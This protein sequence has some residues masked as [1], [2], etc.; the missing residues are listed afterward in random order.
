MAMFNRENTLMSGQSLIPYKS[1]LAENGRSASCG[2]RWRNRKRSE[3]INIAGRLHVSPEETSIVYPTRRS[4]NNGHEKNNLVD[5][6]EPSENGMREFPTY[7]LVTAA[8]SFPAIAQAITNTSGDPVVAL[9]IETCGGNALNPFRGDIR[10]LSLGTGQGTRWLID[11]KATGYDL[12]PLKP[13]LESALLVGHN[14]KFDLR[15]LRHKCGLKATRVFC[16][17]T[18]SRLLA[19][20]RKESKDDLTT[21]VDR[22]LGLTLPQDCS[23]SDWG[24]AQLTKEQ[25]DYAV[26][27][28][29][30]LADLKTVLDRKLTEAKLG[31][32]ASLE[33][34]LILVVVEMEHAG[35]PVDTGKLHR[36]EA[37]CSRQTAAAL[38]QLAK[39]FS[40]PKLNPNSALQLKAGFRKIGLE[41]DGTS[42][43]ALADV[44]HPTVKTLLEHRQASEQLKWVK[45]LIK[46]TGEDGRIH[47]SFNPTGADTGRFT[48]SNP[49]MQNIIRGEVRSC[50]VP[51]PGC[52]LV[53]ADYSQ[54][55]LRAV[56]A[57]ASETRMQEAYRNGEDLHRKTASIILEKAPEQ[58]TKEDRQLAKPVNFGL[59]YGLGAEGLVEYAKKDFGVVLS[60][61]QAET[62]RNRFF[63]EYEGLAQWRQEARQS[64]QGDA[65]ETRT[66]LGR[67]RL[68]PEQTEVWER[69]TR[70][71]NT[72]V[73]GSC[74]DGLK[75]AMVELFKK[76]P[77]GARII[78]TVHDELIVETPEAEAEAVKQL[79]AD[80]MT[81]T[82]EVIFPEVPIEVE[83][84][85]CA[86]WGEK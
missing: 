81:E 20:G 79:V 21:V 73:Q 26:S 10:L 42:A 67:R 52:K 7:D 69:F 22:H 71:V 86:T 57:I 63:T 36:L 76:L 30:H 84:N 1:F 46:F 77:A 83:A 60:L 32:V 5:V 54:I 34:A 53:V 16:T 3:T 51:S 78:S 72:P 19:A 37:E 2:K 27:D 17:M 28:I 82:M 64:A 9:D 66:R 40:N 43:K 65:T 29:S 4:F 50:F 80:T 58:V 39:D 18:A 25:Y 61:E 70:L 47:G 8:A 15:W 35:F 33:M 11:L 6:K 62:F 74:A 41:I 85:V 75:L 23:R 44:D 59:I 49:S 24:K 31:E 45:C 55:E 68:L 13:A 48:S 38:T 14:I 56:A 12:G